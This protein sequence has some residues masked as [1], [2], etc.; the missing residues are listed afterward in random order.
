MDCLVGYLLGCNV[1][2]S[3]VLI[4]YFCIVCM[5][6]EFLR[7]WTRSALWL[8][9]CNNLAMSHE[10][11]SKWFYHWN[12]PIWSFL[13]TAYHENI[14]GISANI[15]FCIYSR[16]LSKN[17]SKPRVNAIESAPLFLFR[18]SF[19]SAPKITRAC[20]F[21][22]MSVILYSNVYASWRYKASL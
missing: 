8:R 19:L 11:Q 7:N 14:V 12:S 18:I 21:W 6:Y 5:N 13:F 16:S 3:L 22:N 15:I 4:Y 20:N 17:T 9:S 10:F 1:C 2:Y